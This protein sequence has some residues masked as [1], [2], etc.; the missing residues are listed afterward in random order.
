MRTSAT[1][2]VGVACLLAI[3]AVT[4]GFVARQSPTMDEAAHLAA[5]IHLWET[6]RCDLYR[7]NP[8][9]TRALAALPALALGSE[10]DW[11]MEPKSVSDRPEFSIGI[12]FVLLNGLEHSLRLFFL[13]RL[14]CISFSLVGAWVCYSWA[15]ELHG[16]EAGWLA[17]LLWCFCP[18]VIAW[19]ATICPDAPAAAMGVAAAYA[20]WRWQKSPSWARAVAAGVMLGAVE[21]TKMTW[22]ILFG[23]WP[24]L[25]LLW[26]WPRRRNVHG[27]SHLTSGVPDAPKETGSKQTTRRSQ[28]VGQLAVILALGLYVLNVGYGFGGTFQRLGNYEFVSRTL[29]GEESLADGGPGGNRFKESWLGLLPVPLPK[30]YLTGMDL[31]K[32]DF[33]QGR[34]S[35][36]CGEWKDNGGWWYYYIVCAALKVPLGTW[37]LGLLALGMTVCPRRFVGRGPTVP[38]RRPCSAGWLNEATLL[39]P[40][41]LAFVLVSSQVGFSRHFRY[42]L[43]AVPFVYIWISKVAQALPL[44]R[45][46][47]AP[48][49]CASTAWTLLSSAW[50]FPHDLAYFNEL[51]GGP[52]HGHHCLIDSNIDWGQDMG[53]LKQ[54]YDQHP[55]ARPIGV[56]THGLLGPHI[57]GID[58]LDVPASPNRRESAARLRGEFGPKPGWYAVSVHRIHGPQHDYFL[59]F[60]PVATVGYSIYIYHVTVDQSNRVRREL[61][62]PQLKATGLPDLHVPGGSGGRGAVPLG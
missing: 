43:P 47:L 26:L 55:E 40:A 44:R 14:V 18:N 62:L 42:V 31:Q 52:R 6:G 50:V 12:G 4:V 54:W 28:P 34:D 29:A 19:G 46:R 51:G 8:P 10:T 58:S 22:I 17:L 36:L 20:Y 9:L 21:L 41:L 56:S 1:T 32:L 5:G 15:R 39:L 2:A 11:S 61:D 48:V 35:F 27:G 57:F 60:E 45:M 23:L 13:A 30:N 59:R 3:H 37:L 24:L 38:S 49:V 25:W 33:E 53:R 16:A 7:V